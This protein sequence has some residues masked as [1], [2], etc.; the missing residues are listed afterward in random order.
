[1]RTFGV[2]LA[3]WLVG[4]G[5]VVALAAPRRASAPAPVAHA[6]LTV[7][8]AAP[9]VA[10]TDNGAEL[11]IPVRGVVASELHDTYAQARSGGR[12]HDAID[13]L[14]PRGTPVIA[15]VDGTIRKLFTSNAGGLTI[16]EFDRDAQRVYYYA[17]LDSYADGLAEGLVVTRGTVIGYVGTTGNAPANTPHLHFAIETLPPTKEWWKGTPLNPY[18][19]LT[20][21]AATLP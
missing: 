19:L 5:V 3:G 12:V 13:I 10:S 7:V 11:L 1:M 16:Y 18:P 14:A 9:P 4:A 21:R 8:S 2:L 15:A 17:H 6:R 20:T